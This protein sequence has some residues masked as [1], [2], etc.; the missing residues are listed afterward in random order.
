MSRTPETWA[1]TSGC[2]RIEIT[3]TTGPRLVTR[4][5]VRD[6]GVGMIISGSTRDFSTRFP[7]RLAWRLGRELKA[8]G[9]RRSS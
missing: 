9:Y 4:R 3:I 1:M 8:Q 6:S 2:D 7:R 5:V